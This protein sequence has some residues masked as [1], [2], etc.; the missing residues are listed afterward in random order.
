MSIQLTV[1]SE[2]E[3][4]AAQHHKK[5][6]PLSGDT[7]LMDSGLDSLCFAVLVARLEDQ[8]GVDPFSTSEEVDA[9]GR[10]SR[11]AGLGHLLRHPPLWRPA[12]L[13]A[14]G[15]RRRLAGAVERRR[16][17]RRT[18]GAAAARGVTHISGTPSHWRALLMSGGARDRAALCAP[19]RRDR[20]PGRARWPACGL[21]RGLIGHAYASTEAGV[22]FEV[23]DGLEGFPALVGP[24]A[25][26]SR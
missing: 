13:S 3:K 16:A 20:R 11:P 7:V 14:R 5:L 1:F 9:R 4:I 10:R 17:D 8:L 2:I 26:A 23:N 22:G 19:V 6:A 12:D 21:P 24:A 25:A 18:S 15:A